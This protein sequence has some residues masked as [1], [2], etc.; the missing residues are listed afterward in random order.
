ML[1]K[2]FSI[3]FHNSTQVPHFA[4]LYNSVAVQVIHC[5][6]YDEITKFGTDVDTYI[7]MLKIYGYWAIAKVVRIRIQIR[8]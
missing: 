3:M 7:Y 8:I 5:A 2:V 4:T 1:W 6:L